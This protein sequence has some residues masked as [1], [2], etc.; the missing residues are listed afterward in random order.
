ME[1]GVS[2]ECPEGGDNVQKVLQA[3]NITLPIETTGKVGEELAGAV[4]MGPGMAMSTDLQ[5]VRTDGAAP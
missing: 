4:Q 1:L 5:I 2:T 3:P